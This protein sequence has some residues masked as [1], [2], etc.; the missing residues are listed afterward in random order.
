MQTVEIER[1]KLDRLI[2]TALAAEREGLQP[3]DR[4]WRRILHRVD[5]SNREPV[6]RKAVRTERPMVPA[7]RV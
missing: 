7:P 1:E 3:P 4:V 5:D 6:F 2:R